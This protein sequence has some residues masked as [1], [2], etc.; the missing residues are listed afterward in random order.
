VYGSSFLQFFKIFKIL[1]LSRPIFDK[2]AKPDRADFPSFL[3]KTDFSILDVNA[4]GKAP[5]QTVI[6]EQVHAN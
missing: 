6:S 4:F 1:N 5:E 2:P 3:K